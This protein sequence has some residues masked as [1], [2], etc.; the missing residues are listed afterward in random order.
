V[1]GTGF[2]WLR[3]FG[4]FA[5]AGMIKEDWTDLAGFGRQAFAYPNFAN[6][7]LKKGKMD[8]SKVCISCSKC[9]EL[10]ANKKKAGCVVRDQSIYLPIY[11]E[12]QQEKNK[13]TV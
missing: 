5:A 6:D 4:I 1:V 7:I 11:K 2:S 3:Q 8:N 9:A 10:K 13:K 12:L